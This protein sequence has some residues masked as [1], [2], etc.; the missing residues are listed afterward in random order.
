MVVPLSRDRKAQVLR[1]TTGGQS[2]H[3]TDVVKAAIV[4]DYQDSEGVME[5]TQAEI[6]KEIAELEKERQRLIDETM[7]KPSGP[8]RLETPKRGLVMS[9]QRR[10]R[11]QS[12]AQRIKGLRAKLV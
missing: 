12:L 11:I 5:K 1:R 2:N 9:S 6:R 10:K 7:G 3:P 8:L 4:K